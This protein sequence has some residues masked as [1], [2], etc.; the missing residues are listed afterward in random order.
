MMQNVKSKGAPSLLLTRITHYEL[1]E[2][3]HSGTAKDTGIRFKMVLK[4]RK[5]ISSNFIFLFDIPDPDEY[6]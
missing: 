2:L 1:C 5:A 6:N 4:I 3:M